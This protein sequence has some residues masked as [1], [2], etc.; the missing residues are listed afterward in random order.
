MNYLDQIAPQQQKKPLF[1]LNLRSILILGGALVVLVIILVTIS[2]LFGSSRLEPW[3][4]LSARLATTAATADSATASIKNNRLKSI[5]SELKIYMV[6]TQRDMTAPLQ[7]LKIDPAKLPASVVTQENG[8]AM[9]QRLEDA[10]LNAKY[11]ST[12]AREM[13][14]QLS[15]ILALLSELYN[16][17]P[18]TA[19]KASLE[20]AYASLEPIQKNLASYS[21]STE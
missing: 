16:S 4:Q 5:N 2:N 6:N 8:E 13:T 20:K 9:M 11:D 21:A 19:T 10:R 18:S 12:Y 1:A 3:Q 17:N 7:T 14:Y 15:T